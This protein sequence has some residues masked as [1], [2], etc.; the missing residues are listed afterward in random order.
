MA[1]ATE[2]V[3]LPLKDTID[4]EGQQFQNTLKTIYKTGGPHRM[5]GAPG[6]ENPSV[7]NLFIDWSN[8]DHHMKFTKWE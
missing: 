3:F 1:E 5:Y 2:I 7:R 4:P 6:V 8:I